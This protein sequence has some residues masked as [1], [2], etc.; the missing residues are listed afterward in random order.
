MQ[1][2]ADRAGRAASAFLRRLGGTFG[3]LAADRTHNPGRAR[4]R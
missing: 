2:R 3:G 4:R 1:R